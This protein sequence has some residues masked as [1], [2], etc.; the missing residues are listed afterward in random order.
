MS[1]HHNTWGVELSHCILYIMMANSFNMIFYWLIRSMLQMIHLY[2][3]TKPCWKDILN[4]PYIIDR[5][6]HFSQIVFDFDFYLIEKFF[7]LYYCMIQ[8]VSLLNLNI[9]Q[10]STFYWFVFRSKSWH[11]SENTSIERSSALPKRCFC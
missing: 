3:E 1:F 6:L 9:I 11:Y 4:V 2:I 10:L 7:T 8:V 5:Q